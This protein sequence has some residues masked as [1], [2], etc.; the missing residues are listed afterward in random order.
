MKSKVK[1]IWV[2]ELD[3]I[4]LI[5][6]HVILGF[7]IY[8][9][10][11][12]R[13]PFY[14]GVILFFFYKIITALKSKKQVWVLAACAYI[15]AGES[16]FRMTGGGLFYEI[17]KYLVI[18]FCLFGM[19]YDGLSGKGYPY[20]IYLILMVPAVVIASINLSYDLRFRSSVAF[21]LS[22][23]VSLGIAALYCYAKRIT[24]EEL[25]Q[26]LK[27]MSMPVVTM[28]VYLFLYT[29][30]LQEVITNTQSNFATS[31]GFGPNQVCTILGIGVFT[32]TVRLFLKSPTFVLKI[33]N[34]IALGLI[35]YRAIITFSRGG[36]FAALITIVA[37]LVVLYFQSGRLRKQQIIGSILLLFIVGI[38]T[39]YISK[40]R[41]NNLIELRYES[42]DASG[43]EKDVS[44]GRLDLFL[45]EF[46]GFRKHPFIGVGAS[47]MKNERF[48]ERGT[49]I[50]SHNEISRLLSEHGMLG[51]IILCILLFKPLSLKI[52]S[53]KNIF[54]YA[55]LAFWFATINHSAMRLAAP[56]FIYA[57]ALL[58]VSYEKNPLRRKRLKA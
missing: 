26:I 48:E 38:S 55:F 53:N 24:F 43:R 39:W 47:G 22:G 11:P 50:A 3:Y 18:V 19:F 51:V 46:E 35:A 7:C 12:L 54:F 29:P 8:I 21:V 57:L 45:E 40:Y 20:F 5:V 52:P 44:T 13:K 42:K 14:L 58:H 37:F 2:Q 23:P 31:G 6:L 4:S 9:V 17:S 16:L 32:F 15:I 56:G 25:L 36:V 49:I 41:T 1:K 27:I 34:S 33:I 28:T 30:S 10:E